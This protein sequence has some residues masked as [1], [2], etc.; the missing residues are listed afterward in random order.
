M[1]QFMFATGIEN[2]YPTILLPDG[3]TKRVDEM[4][5]AGHYI[6]YKEDFRLVAETG[7]KYLRYGPP[8]YNVHKGPGQ[9][10]W[11]F[12]DESF[13]AIK[14]MGI[15]PIVDLCHFGVPDWMGN[16]Q[17]PQFPEIFAEYA[18]AFAKRFPDLKYYTP[19]NEIFITA[20]F[21]A[22]YG[23]WNER[24]T[25]DYSFVTAIKHL[26]KANILA[27]EAILK[28][29]PKAIFIQSES[30]EYFHAEDPTCMAKAEFLNQKRFISMDLTVGREFNTDM[31]FYLMQNGMTKQEYSWFMNNPYKGRVI[32]GTDYYVTNE[33]MV[34]K[35]GS[36][37]AS[38]DIFGYYVI[39]SQYYQRYGLPMMHTETN[40]KE[41]HSV[42]W[43]VK[44]WA[45]LYKLKQDGIP[46]IGFTWYSLIDQVDW[47]TALREDNGNVNSLGLYDINR[48]IRP[49]GEAY[50]Q[51]IA[52]WSDKLH[53][54]WA[55]SPNRKSKKSLPIMVSNS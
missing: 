27:M 51:L 50:K 9:Y 4:E 38:G 16:F 30:C 33:H 13:R 34:H 23:W 31:H 1:N 39:A 37:S 54:K 21:S 36:T 2:S 42:E 45:E 44:Q 28:V 24:K 55:K 53:V 12:T 3:K 25:D 46:I 49:V 40:M 29:Q 32:L 7:I 52:Q 14:E 18:S 6:H 26:C 11:S 48:N 20:M 41:P 22:Q 17:N 35:D 5:K 10:D 8:Y 47:D 43:L 15:I 19:I